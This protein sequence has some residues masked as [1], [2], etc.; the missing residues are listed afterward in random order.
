MS[1][2]RWLVESDL[3]GFSLVFGHGLTAPQLLS[4][5][6]AYSGTLALRDEE[7]F[8]EDFEEELH[9]PDGH[10][11]TAGRYGE[12]AWAWEHYGPR[13]WGNEE[14]LAA[15]SVGTAALVLTSNAKAH[16][17][18]RYAEDGRRLACA[19]NLDLDAGT[20]LDHFRT[21][22]LALG[23]DPDRPEDGPVSGLSLA[24]RLAEGL[25]IDLPPDG[26][27][28]WEGWSARLRP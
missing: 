6:G 15:V 27:P 17:T 1:G 28:V 24:V 8:F 19:D 20:D 25:G 18:F 5:M 12:W 26:P 16:R 10:V 2:L 9:D 7:T 3:S 4:R 21:E 22:L 23:V 11:V 13:R 14:A